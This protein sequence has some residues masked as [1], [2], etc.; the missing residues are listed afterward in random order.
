MS[1]CGPANAGP[2]SAETD[3]VLT[4]AA[5]SAVVCLPAESLMSY[6]KNDA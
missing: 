2:I 6:L 4:G 3:G 5:C 1:A